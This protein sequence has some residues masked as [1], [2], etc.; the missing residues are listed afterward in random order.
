MLLVLLNFGN[1]WNGK[2]VINIWISNRKK[3]FHY[4]FT[5]YN[6]P[7][8]NF[9]VNNCFLFSY[10]SKKFAIKWFKYNLFKMALMT[11]WFLLAWNKVVSSVQILDSL[12]QRLLKKMYVVLNNFTEDIHLLSWFY[13][14]V[15]FIWINK[16]DWNQLC[17]PLDWSFNFLSVMDS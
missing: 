8:Y 3:R 14:I 5:K 13:L 10:L 17:Q 6:G 12:T 11:E 16:D 15:L 2:K 9:M 7:L 4:N 1:K